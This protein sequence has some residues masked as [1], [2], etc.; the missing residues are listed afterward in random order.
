MRERVRESE[1]ERERERD[2]R[3]RGRTR[4]TP[5]TLSRTEPDGSGTPESSTANAREEQV[6]TL[7]HAAT[8]IQ[9]ENS[10]LSQLKGK[11][12]HHN[13]E[14]G[15]KLRQKDQRKVRRDKQ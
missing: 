13:A 3:Y 12:Q 8:L 4:A 11:T 7:P 6:A 15:E 5:A 1:R 10:Y 14:A 9:R 2:G